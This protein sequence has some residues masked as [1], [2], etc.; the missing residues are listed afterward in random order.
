MLAG[1]SAALFMFAATAGAVF[2]GSTQAFDQSVLLALRLPD[3]PYQPVGPDWLL[4]AAKE[5]TALGGTML[6]TL[7]TLLL[8][9]YFAVKRQAATIGLLLAAVIGETILSSLLKDLFDRPRPHIV[10]HLIEASSNSFPSGHATSAA[11]IYLTIA[12]LIARETKERAVRNY[13]YF[14]AV[15]LA[16]LVGASRVYLGVHYPTDVIGGLSIGAFWAAIVL[17]AAR[18]LEKR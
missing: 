3:N 1:A 15:T 16:I 12:A 10:P 6:L 7:F 2:S 4:P 11:A 9:G 17:I 18:R 13:V 8:A 14:S 5:V